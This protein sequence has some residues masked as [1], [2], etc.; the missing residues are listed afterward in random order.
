MTKEFFD[1]EVDALLQEQSRCGVTEAVE[2]DPNPGGKRMVFP[3][4]VPRSRMAELMIDHPCR[5]LALLSPG[6]IN[7]ILED[8]DEEFRLGGAMRSVL[9]DSW[10]SRYHHPNRVA[11]KRFG[12]REFFEVLNTDGPE[13]GLFG[14]KGCGWGVIGLTDERAERIVAALVRPPDGTVWPMGA[15]ET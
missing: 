1:H 9:D 7:A 6:T 5:S 3:L 8:S 4:I 2:A 10:H 11:E 14:L 15:R 13:V 12:W